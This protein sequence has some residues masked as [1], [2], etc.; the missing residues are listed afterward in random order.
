MVKQPQEPEIITI[1]K[2]ISREHNVN[3]NTLVSAIETAIQQATRKTLPQL[4]DLRAHLN[5]TTGKFHIFAKKRVVS[6]VKDEYHEILISEAREKYGQNVELGAEIEVDVSDECADFGRIAAQIAKQTIA[7]RIKQAEWITVYDEF[8]DKIGCLVSGTVLRIEDEGAILD[9]GKTEAL[10]PN[11][12]IPK[13]QK[14]RVKEHLR[15][16]IVEVKQSA[17]RGKQ[18]ILSRTHP[19]LVL[20]LFEQE[21][22]EIKD[23]IVTIKAI[24]RDPGDR[25]KIAVTS[26]D[27]KVEPIGACVGIKGVRIQAVIRELG[28]EKIDVVQ[29]D[30]DPAVFI[31]RA[32]AP[33]KI[34]QVTLQPEKKTAICIVEEDQLSLAIGKKGQNAKLASKLTG[35][36]LDIIAEKKTEIKP[37]EVK[38]QPQQVPVNPVSAS[39]SIS[40]EAEQ[41]KKEAAS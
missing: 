35:W 18:V 27:P 31:A 2:Q 21:V 24:S 3:F 14:I 17:A 11:R 38:S 37:E 1:L 19:D 4:K 28:G 22:P 29:W 20:R 16:V 8:K 7:Q 5:L 34:K 23:G 26:S 32:L 25:T 39:A 15:C 10:L 36:K 13:K 40:T 33:A 12:E 41:T 30:S 9:I 6:E